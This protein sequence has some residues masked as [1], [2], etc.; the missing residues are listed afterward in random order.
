MRSRRAADG[1]PAGREVDPGKRP[2]GA[3]RQD[4]SISQSEK[5]LCLVK[6]LQQVARLVNR[7]RRRLSLEE[8]TPARRRMP[9]GR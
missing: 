1:P 5:R 6:S 2:P 4:V 7:P 8:G 3:R 9:V